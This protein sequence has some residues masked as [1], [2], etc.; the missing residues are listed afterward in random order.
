MPRTSKN[1][2]EDGEYV[3]SSSA[4]SRGTKN[5]K[6]TDIENRPRSRQHPRIPKSGSASPALANPK[7]SQTRKRKQPDI[8]R[9]GRD[10]VSLYTA[11]KRGVDIAAA[12]S[13]HSMVPTNADGA[14]RPVS[15]LIVKLKLRPEVLGGLAIENEGTLDSKHD[16]H[17]LVSSPHEDAPRNLGLEKERHPYH[18]MLSAREGDISDSGDASEEN[19]GTAAL[20]LS[21]E[22]FDP[23][24]KYAD[25][26][27]LMP[28]PPKPESHAARPRALETVSTSNGQMGGAVGEGNEGFAEKARDIETIHK[29]EN[30]SD[31][32]DESD[33]SGSG[34][35]P[36]ATLPQ[37]LVKK[38]GLNNKS[39]AP[40]YNVHD[41]DEAVRRLPPITAETVR[42][43]EVVPHKALPP[44]T[45]PS[46]ASRVINPMPRNFGRG[47]LPISQWPAYQRYR[48]VEY[49]VATGVPPKS[50]P[51]D[52]SMA[53][54][55]SRWMGWAME[56]PKAEKEKLLRHVQ[57]LGRQ[58]KTVA[59]MELRKEE[60]ELERLK[61][62]A[63]KGNEKGKATA[64]KG[65]PRR[66][67]PPGKAAGAAT[68]KPSRKEV[69]PEE[70]CQAGLIK[71][72][73]NGQ[74]F[75]LTLDD[76]SEPSPE[77]GDN[78]EPDGEDESRND[79][80][81][82]G[83]EPPT[84]SAMPPPPKK[85]SE[86][87]GRK[88]QKP[89]PGPSAPIEVTD[90]STSDHEDTQ[91]ISPDHQ[92]SKKRKR[93]TE[94]EN[95]GAGASKKRK[96]HNATESADASAAS[97]TQPPRKKQS[98]KST[99][100]ETHPSRESSKNSPQG[101][102]MTQPQ[103]AQPY[104]DSQAHQNSEA[105]QTN[106]TQESNPTNINGQAGTLYPYESLAP[107][108]LSF[109]MPDT[110]GGDG[111]GVSGGWPTFDPSDGVDGSGGGGEWVG[112]NFDVDVANSDVWQPTATEQDIQ[113]MDQ[114]QQQ[115]LVEFVQEHGMGEEAQIVDEGQPAAGGDDGETGI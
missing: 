92:L 107:A 28:P 104:Q 67:R 86:S 79:N 35:E 63:K 69:T 72:K 59:K 76:E 81:R 60:L 24:K 9:L 11:A 52:Q 70:P 8:Y 26:A 94:V 82:P 89:A 98:V 53:M 6:S 85:G 25:D 23:M 62:G 38:A 87:V 84:N 37:E 31:D 18:A 7:L 83:P 100:Q 13:S 15:E 33:D 14:E 105:H 75:D 57:T 115:L 55:V 32:S 40:R 34:D 102:E 22:A 48:D 110:S 103:D 5:L 41:N 29:D 96:Q 91:Q 88:S 95:T 78:D 97:A 1:R 106:P 42:A 17:S 112:P 27:K 58:M 10:N 101:T 46:T 111:S 114:A 4:A 47:S 3:P 109:A 71:E 66:G 43:M 61:V 90:L 30:D 21:H 108:P 80:E 39:P 74:S 16:S 68:S 49:A 54:L 64:N 56:L 77:H 19:A 44:E 51:R 93:H 65:Q 73:D 113:W 99:Y 36:F 2:D 20:P 50:M 45:S 12:R